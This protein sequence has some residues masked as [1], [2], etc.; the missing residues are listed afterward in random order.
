M[1]LEKQQYDLWLFFLKQKKKV[2]SFQKPTSLKKQVSNTR[3]VCIC[4]P[5]D[6]AHFN[7]ALECVQKVCDERLKITIVVDKDM[8][9]VKNSSSTHVLVYPDG[10]KK[11]FPIKD[12]LLKSI[13]E[14][15]DVAVDLSSEPG[16]LSAYI[17]GTRGRKM[18]V[19]LKSGELDVF[20][21]ALIEPIGEYKEAVKTML[22][23]AGLQVNE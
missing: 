18:T 19:G 12:E 14:H 4:M 21:T 17:T 3:N 13:P 20:Y 8:K 16:I 1:I 15:F 5:R 22:G 10:M 9:D 7:P 2:L 23:V 6:H 11:S